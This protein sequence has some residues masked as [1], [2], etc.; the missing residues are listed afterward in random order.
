MPTEDGSIL[1]VVNKMAVANHGTKVK[2]LDRLL[3]RHHEVSPALLARLALHDVLV[4]NGGR[5]ELGKRSHQVCVDLVVHL[6]QAQRRA[7]DALEDGP[8]GLHVLDDC[9]AVS[10]QVLVYKY[11]VVRSYP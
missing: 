8:V 10:K 4:D 5:V 6:G 3:V 2:V 9:D 11:G 7:L 1:L